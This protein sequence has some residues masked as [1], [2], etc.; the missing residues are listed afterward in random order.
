M[1]AEN[2]IPEAEKA[3]A[4]L[5]QILKQELNYCTCAS[6]E[7]L[8]IL[9]LTLSYGRDIP[10]SPSKVP[11]DV[12]R[13][14]MGLGEWF[15]YFLE[16][17]DLLSHGFNNLDFSL[18]EKGRQLLEDMEKH[19]STIGLNL[20]ILNQLADDYY[21]IGNYS[22]ALHTIDRCLTYLPEYP[23]A[24]HTKAEI[25]IAMER[26][27]EAL[28]AVSWVIAEKN[29]LT[30]SEEESPYQNLPIWEDVYFTAAIIYFHLA[31]YSEAL[32][33]I[34]ISLEFY[35]AENVKDYRKMILGYLQ[36]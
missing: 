23:L 30:T 7:V 32:Q 28:E 24:Y 1:N 17:K 22:L 6:A 3:T 34:D 21:V 25:L 13:L 36:S 19:A 8:Q 9:F 29:N 12:D 18:T 33:A 35:P 20:E 5:T 10:H 26:Y 2:Q 4:R 31:R 27:E 14:P 15:I 16:S 11:T